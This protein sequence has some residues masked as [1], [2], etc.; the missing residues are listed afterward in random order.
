MLF[1]EFYIFVNQLLWTTSVTAYI[2]NS[3]GASMF[4]D[5]YSNYLTLSA[6]FLYYSVLYF[7]NKISILKLK[8]KI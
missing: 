1:T 4:S 6:N 8:K 7:S 3:K 2:S 5:S